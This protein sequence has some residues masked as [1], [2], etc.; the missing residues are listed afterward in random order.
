[1][2]WAGII[3]LGLIGVALWIPLLMS[4]RRPKYPPPHLNVIVHTRDDRSIEGVQMLRDQWGILLGAAKLLNEGSEQDVP[5]S[6]NVRIPLE[7]IR[8]SQE[9]L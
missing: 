4:L 5:L 9:A 6:G 1:M 3:L 7:N 8:M 2:I